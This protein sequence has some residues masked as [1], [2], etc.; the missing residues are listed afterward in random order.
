MAT[1]YDALLRT[2]SRRPLRA[3]HRIIDALPRHAQ[4]ELRL[5]DGTPEE[6]LPALADDLD[7]ALLVVGS[8]GKGAMRGALAGSVSL[9]LARATAMPLVVVPPGCHPALTKPA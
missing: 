9:W 8:R 1:D 3:L 5:L 6:Q 7:A 4:V 2:E